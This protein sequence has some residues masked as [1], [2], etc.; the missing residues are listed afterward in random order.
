M[1]TIRYFLFFFI[2]IIYCQSV[3]Y[4]QGVDS[5]SINVLL[6]DANSG[7]LD[8]ESLLQFEEAWRLSK[9]LNYTTG[10]KKSLKGLVDHHRKNARTIE[11]LKY[12]FQL[13]QLLLKRNLKR[14]LYDNSIV[15]GSLYATENITNK[16][17]ES[18]KFAEAIPLPA[19]PFLEEQL[20]TLLA[21][22]YIQIEDYDSASAQ[23][24]KL[25]NRNADNKNKQIEILQQ[26]VA[27]TDAK[28]NYAKSLE[29]NAEIKVL[30]EQNG[31]QKQI[32]IIY[33]NIANTYTHLKDYNKAIEYFDYAEK[34]CLKDKY[35][36]VNVLYINKAIT[37][38]NNNNFLAAMQYF[39]KARKGINSP[40]DKAKVEH[41]VANIYL[42]NRDPYNALRS[43]NIAIEEALKTKDYYLLSDTYNTAAL[44]Y[45]KIYD[46]ENAFDFYKKHLIIK[47]SLLLAALLKQQNMLQQQSQLEKSE[48][49]TKLLLSNQEIQDLTIRQLEIEKEKLSF[50]SLALA[51]EASKQDREIALLKRE[52]EVKTEK[53]RNAQLESERTQQALTLA[54]EQLIAAQKDKQIADLNKLEQS[55]RLSLI[56]QQNQ[57]QVAE[58]QKNQEI[59]KLQNDKEREQLIQKNFREDAYRFGGIAAFI[60]ALLVGLGLYGRRIN[61]KLKAQKKAIEASNLLIE[62][63][64]AKSES[65]LRNIL[66]EDTVAELKQTGKSTSRKYEMVSVIFTDFVNFTKIAEHLSPEELIEELNTCFLG[67]DK[68]IERNHLEKIKTIGDSYMCVGGLPLANESNPKDAVK[69]AIEMMDFMENYN[70][71]RALKKLK[72]IEMRLG[73]HTGEAIAGVVGSKKFA[74]DVW[75]DT[76]NTASRMES[77]GEPGRVNISETTYLRVKNEF[78]CT[79][80]GKIK[81]KNKGEMGMYFVER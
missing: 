20:T 53:L 9:Q 54:K 23:F 26:L 63:E 69:A 44:A 42:N 37:Y 36:D 48:K 80:R 30:V 72:P 31:D 50:Q 67:F 62:E 70:Q 49:E 39:D 43:N 66:P 76:V 12:A 8:D 11:A 56:E 4:A 59:Q 77:A 10:I 58:N 51:A 47:D 7:A 73:I 60:M 25:L 14:E 18:Y 41:L 3:T 52:E 24:Q 6:Q 13:N 17:I 33:N 74:Y 71:K 21:K 75:G 1:R 35:L 16:A 68:I 22:A 45:Q 40:N 81:A 57:Q 2:F 55:Q 19:N 79:F 65:L 27:C 64:R 46:Y 38:S 5:L 15:I 61:A 28:K 29:Y 32:A 78:N 34:L